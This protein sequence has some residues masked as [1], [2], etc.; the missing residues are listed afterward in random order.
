MEE[1]REERRVPVKRGARAILAKRH[2]RRTIE[3]RE[4]RKASPFRVVA[5][6]LP[7]GSSSPP[8]LLVVSL[9]VIAIDPC[10]CR[11]RKSLTRI[12]AEGEDSPPPLRQ[13][14]PCA[15]TAACATAATSGLSPL[16]RSAKREREPGKRL[17]PEEKP[18]LPPC[19]A[20]GKTSPPSPENSAGKDLSWSSFPLDF[21]KLH[22]RC[23]IGFSYRRRRS[24]R[25]RHSRWLPG[26]PANQVSYHRYFVFLVWLGPDDCVSHKCC[27]D[28]CAVPFLSELVSKLIYVALRLFLLLR[29][30]SGAGILVV[31]FGPRRKAFL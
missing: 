10:P 18:I 12:G 25:R 14:P 11:R 23:M 20:A 21:R 3:S 26:L 22:C 30:I 4:E 16:S 13:S 5:P 28:C 6:T 8:S 29:K 9:G 19:L 7:S 2:C 31:G 1:I 27:C 24:G 17:L 15:I